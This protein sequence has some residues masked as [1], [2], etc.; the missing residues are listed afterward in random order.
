MLLLFVSEKENSAYPVGDTQPL[1]FEKCQ[2]MTIWNFH[3]DKEIAMDIPII[4]ICD[5]ALQTTIDKR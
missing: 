2:L 1:H 5:V 4:D 3:T